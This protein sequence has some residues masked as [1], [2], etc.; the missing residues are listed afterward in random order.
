[1]DN[2]LEQECLEVGRITTG[3]KQLDRKMIWPFWKWENL[4]SRDLTDLACPG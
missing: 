2:P 1:M 4:Q 3:S